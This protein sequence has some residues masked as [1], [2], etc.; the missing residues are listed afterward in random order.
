[1]VSNGCYKLLHKKEIFFYVN[2]KMPSTESNL[3]MEN[4]REKS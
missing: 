1:M 3:L 2:K 4:E